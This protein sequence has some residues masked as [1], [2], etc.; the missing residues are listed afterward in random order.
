MTTKGKVKKVICLICGQEFET[1]SVVRKYCSQ[2]CKREGSAR[3]RY[4][5]RKLRAEEKE[6]QKELLL[7]PELPDKM[8]H[9]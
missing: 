2:K 3:S 6:C 9:I 1:R 4:N 8:V 5:N 7:L